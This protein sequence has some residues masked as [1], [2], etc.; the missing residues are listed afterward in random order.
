MSIQKFQ[1]PKWYDSV[2]SS[3]YKFF[4]ILSSNL[5]VLDMVHFVTQMVHIL[6]VYQLKISLSLSILSL[7]SLH[8]F[9][10]VRRVYWQPCSQSNHLYLIYCLIKEPW[11]WI[12]NI[13]GT[14]KRLCARMD[15]LTMQNQHILL[16]HTVTEKKFL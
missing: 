7:C 9:A 10:L 13:Q 14:S 1:G 8:K 5:K 3:K 16:V 4:Q 6:R 12:K 15:L 2:P 11:Y